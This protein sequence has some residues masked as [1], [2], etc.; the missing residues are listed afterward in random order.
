M[1]LHEW[2]Y[3][4]CMSLT[5]ICEVPVVFHSWRTCS[6]YLLV[7]WP[8]CQPPCSFPW[9]PVVYPGLGRV[10]KCHI[11]WSRAGPCWRRPYLHILLSISANGDVLWSLAERFWKSQSGLWNP[12]VLLK[13]T[14]AP[15]P[16]WFALL[17]SNL[18]AQLMLTAYGCPGRGE[19]LAK[20][21][22]KVH[23]WM[24]KFSLSSWMVQKLLFSSLSAPSCRIVF[25][26]FL[27]I[28][29]KGNLV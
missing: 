25:F 24:I 28:C 5:P 10:W 12:S 9:S 11:G 21:I 6:T 18:P 14:L 3:N 8:V 27:Q 19:R 2:G 1:C 13:Q 22:I 4:S 17:C 7:L 23:T 26:K 20:T 29:W 15:A 16:D